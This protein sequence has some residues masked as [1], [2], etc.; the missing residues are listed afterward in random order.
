M[1]FL[2]TVL[3]DDIQA[4]LLIILNLIVLQKLSK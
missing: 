4:A 3:G 1:A 2:H